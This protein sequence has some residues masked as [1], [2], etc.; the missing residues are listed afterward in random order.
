MVFLQTDI[1]M[2]DDNGLSQCIGDEM[3]GS[4]CLTLRNTSQP[5]QSI[6]TIEA[7][8]FDVDRDSENFT[9]DAF[10]PRAVASQNYPT[11]DPL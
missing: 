6:S 5:S 2:P 7:L 1:A 10:D 9:R 8:A 4:A 3:A 11:V